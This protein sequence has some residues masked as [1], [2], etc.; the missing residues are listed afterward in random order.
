MNT[1]ITVNLSQ[2][3]DKMGRL[4][5][6]IEKAAMK[7]IKNQI[8]MMQRHARREHRFMNTSGRRPNGRYYRN[9]HMLVKSIET[10]FD[11]MKYPDSKSG[12]MLYLEDGIADYGKYVHEGHGSWQPDQFIYDAF[13]QREA[14]ILPGIMGA[15]EKACAEI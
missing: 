2:F 8:T 11:G 10:D 12:G 15:V 14:F 1:S 3:K 4:P 5:I 13:K 9:T 6:A 7:E